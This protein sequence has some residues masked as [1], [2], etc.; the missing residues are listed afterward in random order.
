M[1]AR[2][3][4]A[5]TLLNYIKVSGCIRVH[6][7]RK[8][9]MMTVEKLQYTKRSFGVAVRLWQLDILCVE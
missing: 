2:E 6:Q 9:D 4:N 7:C 5:D 1:G 8:H 3:K